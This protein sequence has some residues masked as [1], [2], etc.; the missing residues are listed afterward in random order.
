VSIEGLIASLLITAVILF[1]VLYPFL[2][3]GG[4]SEA[5]FLDRQRER[6][7]A[8]Y[9]RVLLNV[10]DLDEDHATGKIADDEY[11]TEREYWL[12][13]GVRLLRL[14]DQLEQNETLTPQQTTDDAVIDAAIESAIESARTDGPEA[15]PDSDDAETDSDTAQSEDYAK[16]QVKQ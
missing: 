12:E 4:I 8:Y 16:V 7:L 3:P 11:Q 15:N 2:R 6:A 9:E 14:L 10:R 1:W 13:R 5:V